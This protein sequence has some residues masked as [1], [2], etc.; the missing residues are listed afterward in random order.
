MIRIV[1][2]LGTQRYEIR[3]RNRIRNKNRS[4]IRS[5]DRN[6]NKNRIRS[7]NRNRKEE[8]TIETIINSTLK[9]QHSNLNILSS[10]TK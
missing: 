2:F 8:K 5:R 4:R 1:V 7:R 3:S 9:S 10:E 6:T